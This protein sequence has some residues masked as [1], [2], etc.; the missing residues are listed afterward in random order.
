MDILEAIQSAT[1]SKCCLRVKRLS[2]D[3][4]THVALI[5]KIQRA[6]FEAAADA[7]N[8]LSPL[9]RQSYLAQVTVWDAKLKMGSY[10]KTSVE[11]RTGSL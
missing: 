11:F 3:H 5:E 1:L 8:D 10:A 7:L 4:G 2:G 9:K 6:V